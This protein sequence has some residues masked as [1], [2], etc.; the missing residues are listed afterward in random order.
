MD[1]TQSHVPLVSFGTAAIAFAVCLASTLIFFLL[2]NT[3]RSSKIPG[4]WFTLPLIGEMIPFANNPMKFM[5]Q[6]YKRYNSL[7]FRTQLFGKE[8][9]VV[10]DPEE[11]KGQ[12]SDN[13]LSESIMPIDTFLQLLDFSQMGDPHRHKLFRK[14]MALALSPANIKLKL[15][16]FE[17]VVHDEVNFW[18]TQ[19]ELE[20][21]LEVKRLAVRLALGPI[22]GLPL[23]ERLFNQVLNLALKVQGG[24]FGVPINLPGTNWSKAKEARPQYL[25]LLRSILSNQFEVENGVVKNPPDN[26][27]G[28]LDA[29]T[30]LVREFYDAKVRCTTA[31]VREFYDAKDPPTLDKLAS[32]LTQNIMGASDTSAGLLLACLLAASEVPGVMDKMREEQAGLVALHGR[33][34]DY[35]MLQTSMPYVDACVREAA[36]L[37]P[38]AHASFRRAKEDLQVGGHH[39]PKG[40][41]IF[42]AWDLMSCVDKATWDCSTKGALPP[43][44]DSDHLE[45]SFKPE[46]IHVFSFGSHSCLGQSLA[47]LELKMVLAT[48]VRERTWEVVNKN[49]RLSFVPYTHLAGGRPLKLRFTGSPL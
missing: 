26:Q 36:R 9:I 12:L 48:L 10:G 11:R 39:I 13:S 41:V 30:A 4:P 8:M 37:L 33:K 49:P 31:P 32:R 47:I 7:V 38:S 1:S 35:D 42:L 25:A 20:M 19:P 34:I 28:S 23:S 46:S 17:A 29:T 44:M 21:D 6:R 43:A 15:P 40:S 27:D 14:H 3:S 2:R 16:L 18:I 45:S 24:I 22:G 5:F